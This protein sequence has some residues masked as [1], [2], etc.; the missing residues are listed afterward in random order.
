MTIDVY[1]GDAKS[2]SLNFANDDGSPMNVSG[3]GVFFSASQTFVPPPAVYVGTT[4]TDAAAVTGL[5]ILGLSSSD[6]SICVGDYSAFFR[7]VDLS[8]NASTFPTEGLSI[9]P[10]TF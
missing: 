2:L 6:T 8:G 10:T 1:Q 9:L 3:Y 4:G 7:L 5:V